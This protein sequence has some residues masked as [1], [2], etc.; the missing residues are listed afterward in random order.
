[1]ELDSRPICVTVTFSTNGGESLVIS[2]VK[3]LKLLKS[4]PEVGASIA[5]FQQIDPGV[6]LSDLLLCHSISLRV[7]FLQSLPQYYTGDEGGAVNP[8]NKPVACPIM[9]CLLRKEDV[10]SSYAAEVAHTN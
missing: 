7:D 3:L 8:Q 1:M 2:K 9:R 10:R 4:V 6:L 5:K